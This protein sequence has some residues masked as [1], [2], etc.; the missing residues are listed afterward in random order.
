M[1][2]AHPGAGRN[3]SR[4]QLDE[5]AMEPLLKPALQTFA[6]VIAGL[7][8]GSMFGIWRGY[9][10]AAF[11]A[12]A[13]LE[14]HQGAVRGLNLL[15]PL[16]GL[17]TI[18]MALALAYLSGRGAS[19]FPLYLTAAAG[20][21]AA[22]VVTRFLNQPINAEIMGWT[23]ATVPAGWEALRDTWWSWHQVRLASTAAGFV[24]LVL[25]ALSDRGTPQ[26]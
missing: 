19:A 1:T 8:A 16:M 9:N 11:S 5:D 3:P 18:L 24:L 17:T 2:L 4:L 7:L 15:L 12:T 23:S 6:I 14:M 10:P 25:A 13:F 26:V 20:F 21:I 22:G